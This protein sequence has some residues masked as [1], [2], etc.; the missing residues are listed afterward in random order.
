MLRISADQCHTS[1]VLVSAPHFRTTDGDA[2]QAP[3][4]PLSAQL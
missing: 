4:S 2:N 1:N 3:L